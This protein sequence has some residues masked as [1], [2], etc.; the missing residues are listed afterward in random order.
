M[1]FGR[2]PSLTWR[3]L[4]RWRNNFSHRRAASPVIAST[5]GP[6]ECDKPAEDGPT[7]QKV[8][9]EDR[10]EFQ[11]LFAPGPARAQAS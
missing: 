1:D 10:R 5:E 2:F 11:R 4:L 6:R 8:D 9:E 3:L 7:E